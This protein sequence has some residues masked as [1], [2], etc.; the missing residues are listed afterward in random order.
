MPKSTKREDIAILHPI[1]DA[2]FLYYKCSMTN[3]KFLTKL[4]FE[5]D[6]NLSM[7][8]STSLESIDFNNLVSNQPVT[9]QV[10]YVYN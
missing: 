3:F 9:C 5:I 8:Q 6:I 1:D 2:F 4:R 7:I 10:F